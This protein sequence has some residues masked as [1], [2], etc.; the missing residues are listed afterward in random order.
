MK[1][2]YAKIDSAVTRLAEARADVRKIA[3]LR[4]GMISGMPSIDEENAEFEAALAYLVKLVRT[5]I[6]NNARLSTLL[7]HLDGELITTE[8]VKS[9]IQEREWSRESVNA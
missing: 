9:E 5:A 2:N 6:A 3:S 4:M 1:T 7:E 8:I